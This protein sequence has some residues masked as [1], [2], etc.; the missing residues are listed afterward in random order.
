M[1]AVSPRCLC[2][3][4][5]WEAGDLSEGSEEGTHAS[6]AST[7]EATAVQRW[8]NSSCRRPPNPTKL[9]SVI[10][11]VIPVGSRAFRDPRECGEVSRS[12]VRVMSA[13]A[14]SASSVVES[15]YYGHGLGFELTQFTA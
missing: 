3:A 12:D 6:Q 13:T 15:N 11:N 8:D 9:L 2:S 10:L 1:V 7:S 14:N 4:K 5:S